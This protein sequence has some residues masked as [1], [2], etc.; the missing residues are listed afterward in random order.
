LFK[1]AVFT[2]EN[3][4][5]FPA[6]PEQTKIAHFLMAVDQKIQALKKKKGLLEDYK[7]GVM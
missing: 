7:K 4:N 3:R 5:F 2:R 1:S 6:L